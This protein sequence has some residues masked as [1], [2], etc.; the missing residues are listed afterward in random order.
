[1]IERIMMEFAAEVGAQ[2]AGVGLPK[3]EHGISGGRQLSPDDGW[4]GPVSQCGCCNRWFGYID[5]GSFGSRGSKGRSW[6]PK[7]RCGH[8]GGKYESWQMGDV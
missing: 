2:M 1:M 5:S 6:T 7:D 3:C 4:N 8:C